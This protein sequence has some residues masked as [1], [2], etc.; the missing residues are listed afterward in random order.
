MNSLYFATD[1]KEIKIVQ[2]DKT[3]DAI[4]WK[5]NLTIDI[6]KESDQVEPV[7]ITFGFSAEEEGL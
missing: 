4:T 6:S 5:D 2:N 1:N 7:S 3:V